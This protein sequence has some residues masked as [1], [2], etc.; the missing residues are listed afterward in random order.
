[1]K[2]CGSYGFISMLIISSLLK[3]RIFGR[4]SSKIKQLPNNILIIKARMPKNQVKKKLLISIISLIWAY[5]MC[6]HTHHLDFCFE[7]TL[8]KDKPVI[9]SS[10]NFI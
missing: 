9:S 7:I 1:M 6:L 10:I 4:K 3:D 5:F 2:I 8:P